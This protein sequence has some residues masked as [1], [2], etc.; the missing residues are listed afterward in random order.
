MALKIYIIFLSIISYKNY[1]CVVSSDNGSDDWIGAAI[2][3][4]DLALSP[5]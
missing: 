2:G 4:K 5:L 3:F 1:L